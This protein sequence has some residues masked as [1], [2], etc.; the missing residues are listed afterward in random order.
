MEILIAAFV[1][2]LHQRQRIV[3]QIVNAAALTDHFSGKCLENG[4]IGGISDI[5]VSIGLVD[6]IY[7][8]SLLPEFFSYTF[9]YSVRTAG[10][11]SHLFPICRC[12]DVLLRDCQLHV[13]ARF[14]LFRLLRDRF[15]QAMCCQRCRYSKA[16]SV[17]QVIRIALELY[18]LLP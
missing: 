6:H 18:G 7:S 14:V 9:P 8:D 5:V 16:D 12:T 17:H 3:D 10:H 2:A 11:N 1:D 4:F 15:T 13:K